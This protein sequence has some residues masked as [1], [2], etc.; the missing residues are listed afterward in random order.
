MLPWCYGPCQPFCHTHAPVACL[1]RLTGRAA[2]V[3]TGAAAEQPA[4]AA[5]AGPATLLHSCPA[6]FQATAAPVPG[7][8]FTAAC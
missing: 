8:Q 5:A 6:E 4:A 1:G 2:E 7:T 3:V